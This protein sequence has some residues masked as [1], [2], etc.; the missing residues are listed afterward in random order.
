MFVGSRAGPDWHGELDRLEVEVVA[1]VR[2]VAKFIPGARIGERS[3]ADR[4]RPD[5]MRQAIADRFL[6][7]VAQVAVT[8]ALCAMILV[9]FRFDDLRPRMGRSS[10]RLRRV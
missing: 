8:L 6:G 7:D 4:R 2:Q 5:A 1:R 3:A 10:L 9:F